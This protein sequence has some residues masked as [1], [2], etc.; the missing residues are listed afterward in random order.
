MLQTDTVQISRL[1]RPLDAEISSDEE[2]D[3]EDDLESGTQLLPTHH[4]QPKPQQNTKSTRLGDVWDERDELFNIGGDSDDED[5]PRDTRVPK[6][7]VSG[8]KDVL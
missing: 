6:I 3:D 7:V 4:S 8:S 5:E 2:E 1:Y